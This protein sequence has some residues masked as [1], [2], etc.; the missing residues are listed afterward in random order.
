MYKAARKPLT[1]EQRRVLDIMIWKAHRIIG[2][3]YTTADLREGITHS[4][5]KSEMQRVGRRFNWYAKKN[6]RQFIILPGKG[7]TRY[8]TRP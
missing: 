3:S 8:Q 7:N 6:P 1:P 5:T 4:L 2:Q